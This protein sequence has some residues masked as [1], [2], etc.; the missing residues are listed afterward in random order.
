VPR[1]HLSDNT[2]EYL[3]Y[4]KKELE[5]ACVSTSEL[6]KVSTELWVGYVVL[7]TWLMEGV[8]EVWAFV[9]TRCAVRGNGGDGRVAMQWKEDGRTYFWKMKWVR[10]AC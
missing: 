4:K 8:G 1:L 9:M 5:S 10:C 6:E 2:T 7:N 3:V